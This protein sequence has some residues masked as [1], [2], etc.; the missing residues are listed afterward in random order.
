MQD[1]ATD[2]FAGSELRAAGPAE[3][4]VFEGSKRFAHEERPQEFGALARDKAGAAC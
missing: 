1:V 3:L 4:R 2:T